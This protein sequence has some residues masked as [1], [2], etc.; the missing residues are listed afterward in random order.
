VNTIKQQISS[1]AL[2]VKNPQTQATLVALVSTV[3][4]LVNNLLVAYGA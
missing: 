4:G 1:G 3:Q 2:N